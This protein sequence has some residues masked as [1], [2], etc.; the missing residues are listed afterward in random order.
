[1]SNNK[2]IVVSGATAT[3]KTAYS[4]ELATK[5]QQQG[6]KVVIINFDSLL[7]YKELNIGT[8]KPTI[9]EQANITHEMINICSAHSPINA[10]DYAIAAQKHIHV[11]LQSSYQVILVGGSGFYVR[12][13]IKGMYDSPPI[14]DQTRKEVE[15]I[16]SNSGIEGIRALLKKHDFIS[17]STLHKN[18]HY[19]NIRALEHWIE[20]RS[21]LS[22]EKKKF[23]QN[24][25]YDFSKNTH[26]WNIDHH[27]LQVEKERHWQIILTRAQ[28]MVDQGLINEVE[29]L[30]K[31]GFSGKEKPLQSIGYK[32]TIDYLTKK[33]ICED[34]LI[35]R[36]YIATR[37]LAKAQKT[38]FKKVTPKNIIL[39]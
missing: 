11:Y 12:A 39:R 15:T 20:H 4:I 2:I 33:N 13:L 27:Y 16:F 36:I 3:G 23:E 22:E 35:E 30:L 25:P 8:A 32:E 26:N 5:L 6:E 34:E 24:N 28:K 31:S 7:F 29:T 21:P 1:M 9:K 17:F 38:F 18:D 14:S 37:R 19:R 10:H